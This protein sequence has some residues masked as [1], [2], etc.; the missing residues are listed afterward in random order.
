[1]RSSSDPAKYAGENDR[2]LLVGTIVKP[3]GIRGELKVRSYTERVENLCRY[4]LLYIGAADGQNL[5]E[6]TVDRAR[7]NGSTIILSVNEC[8]DRDGAERLVGLHLW[9]PTSALPPAG[10]KEFYLHTLLGKRAMTPAG[11]ELGQV[12]GVLASGQDLLVIR[13]GENEIFVPAVKS[14]IAAIGETDLVLDLPPGLLEINRSNG[15]AG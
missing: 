14:F 15:T 5:R 6:Y 3:H 7:V 8:S 10:P 4:P 12:T 2:F 1:M 11:Q 9:L 13:D